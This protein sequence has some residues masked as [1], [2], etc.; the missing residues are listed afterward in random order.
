MDITALLLSRIQFAFTISF[1]IV[2]PAF[3]IG[4]VAW[5]SL[6]E[7]LH[8]KTGRPAYRVLFEFD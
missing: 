3:S 8:L 5:L 4:V 7:A 6:L 1:H 2:F